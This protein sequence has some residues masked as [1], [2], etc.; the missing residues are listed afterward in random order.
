MFW[1]WTEI[2]L[3][4][5]V[6]FS[7]L[8]IAILYFVGSG[9]LRLICGIYKKNDPIG[10]FDFVQRVTFDVFF[11]LIFISFS[12]LVFSI[13]SVPILFSTIILV[14]LSFFGFVKQD[15]KSVV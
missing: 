4:D 6:L 12:V 3:F 2:T 5:S 13:F 10:E 8:A 7:F 9:L 11:G 14:V 1:D 15:R